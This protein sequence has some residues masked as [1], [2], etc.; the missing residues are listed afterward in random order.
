MKWIA[1][2]LAAASPAAAEAYKINRVI[3]GD[4]VEIAVDFLPSPL[5]P[6]LS[7]RVLGVDTP[8]K[9]PRAKCDAEAAKAKMASEFTKSAVQ[10]ATVVDVQIKEWDKYGGRVLG[11]IYLDS[12]NLAEMLIAADLARP[13]KGDAKS[14]WCE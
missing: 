11:E 10:M 13:Y 5:P 2:L 3:D 14:S 9:A 8:E 7:I 12:K 6:K 1:I 4:T